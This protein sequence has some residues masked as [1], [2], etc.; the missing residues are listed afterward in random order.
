MLIKRRQRI[1]LLAGVLLSSLL[2]SAACRA[3]EPTTQVRVTTSMGEF[4]IEVRND[5]APLTAANFLRYVREGFYTNTLF[6]RVIA[7]F[8]IQGGGHDAT[9]QQLKPTHDPVFNE[10]GNG[11][12]NKRGT[13]GLAR[14]ESPHSGTAQFYVN[15]VDNPDLDP[16]P[17]RW[18]YT[19]FGRVVQGMDVIEHIG[20]TPTGAAGPFKNDSPLKPVVI[21]KMEIISGQV[22]APAPVTP[23]TPPAPNTILSPK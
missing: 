12:Q 9:T 4:V 10:S 11:L 1:G 15:L 14:G 21:E 3:A 18:G 16:V 19:V 6:H 8:V 2:L 5:R 7:N 20:E 13:V 17:T 22:A 23:V